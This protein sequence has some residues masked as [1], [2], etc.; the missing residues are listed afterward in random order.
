MRAW[1]VALHNYVI[2]RGFGIPIWY[3]WHLRSDDIAKAKSFPRTPTCGKAMQKGGVTGPPSFRFTTMT[4]QDTA[5]I[6]SDIRSLTTFSV[7]AGLPGRKAL[8]MVSRKDWIMVLTVRAYGHDPDD[9][10]KVAVVTA[11]VDTAKAF[12]YWKSD[13]LKKR[14]ADNGVIGEP[15]RFVFR[16]VQRY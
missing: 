16:V 5:H 11:V 13:M 10:N 8:R 7:K 4:F 15:E 2:G 3:W 9:S 12:A 6:S 1:L 14:R